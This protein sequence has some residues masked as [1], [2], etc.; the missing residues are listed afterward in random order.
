MSK[1]V[2]F[3]EVYNTTTP[4]TT[5]GSIYETFIQKHALREVW[6]NTGQI[7]SVVDCD[8]TQEV[9]DSLPEDLLTAAGFSSISVADSSRLGSVIQVVGGAKYVAEQVNGLG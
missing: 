9:L 6:V 7:I 4:G 5:S 1:L 8:M 3:Y 2:K